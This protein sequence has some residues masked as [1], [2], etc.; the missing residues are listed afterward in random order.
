MSRMTSAGRSLSL[1]MG[2]AQFGAAPAHE[3]ASAFLQVSRRS[4]LFRP[5]E[6]HYV[7]RRLDGAVSLKLVEAALKAR[8][9]EALIDRTEIYAFEEW[10]QRI[11]TLIGRADTV[12]FVLSPDSV[13]SDVARARAKS[14]EL[15]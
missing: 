9:F 5:V 11:E 1:L 13:A 3:L 7:L 14:P 15:S 2:A 8:G 10:W 4:M 6:W 12:V